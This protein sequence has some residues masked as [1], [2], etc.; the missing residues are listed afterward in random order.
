[1]LSKRHE[2][3][4]DKKV[5]ERTKQL[6]KEKNHMQSILDSS[7]NIVLVTKGLHI[8]SSN[9]SFFN[10]FDFKDI[11]EFKKNYDCICDFFVLFDDKPFPKDKMIEGELWS[12]YLLNHQDEEHFVIL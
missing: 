8:I 7:T 1:M 11:H 5:I 12:D 6:N 3:E 9:K 10:F 2:K 4:L